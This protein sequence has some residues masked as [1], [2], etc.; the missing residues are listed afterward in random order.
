[1]V[2]PLRVH[3]DGGGEEV[4]VAGGHREDGGDPLDGELLG[5]QLVL[6]PGQA[7]LDGDQALP[8]RGRGRGR[9]RG[10]EGVEVGG[11]HRPGLSLPGRR[12]GGGRRRGDRPH[13]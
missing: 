10:A 6:L 4:L 7:A 13:R 2:G 3:R 9:G 1:R 12:R 8:G 11:G 5:G